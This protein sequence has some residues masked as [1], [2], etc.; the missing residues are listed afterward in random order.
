MSRIVTVAAAL[1]LAAVALL[2]SL[3]IVTALNWNR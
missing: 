2:L 1:A 3:E